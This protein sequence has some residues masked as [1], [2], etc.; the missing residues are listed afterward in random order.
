MMKKIYTQVVLI[1]LITVIGL[2]LGGAIYEWI[3][4]AS[5]WSAY[6]PVSFAVLQE[7]YG[8][9]L[10]HFWIP[11]HM[12]AQVLIVFAV[13]LCWKE[14]SIR[15]LLLWVIGLYLL[16]RIPTFLYFIPELGAFTNADPSGSYSQEW[17]N[18]ADLWVNLSIVRT[19]IVVSVY[20]LS[21]IGYNRFK[22]LTVK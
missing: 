7:P 11:L 8:L 5:Q 1:S 2:E 19:I 6:P 15:K 22:S 20:V 4:V 18:R 3:V 10:E 13:I 9:P 12:V 21:W 14:R 16:L 17:K